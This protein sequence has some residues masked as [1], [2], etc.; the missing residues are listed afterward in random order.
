MRIC[1]VQPAMCSTIAENADAA[2]KWTRIAATHGAD[3]VAFPEMMLTGYDSH[4]HELF[5][6]PDWYDEVE[7]E[8]RG[9]SGVA[10]ETET[11]ILVGAPYRI[12]DHYLNAL[13]LLEGD[14]KPRLAGARGFIVE[15]WRKMWGF[16]EARDRAP[17]KI[18]GF[19]IGSIFC[20]E[21]S[22]LERVEDVG[23]EESEIILWPSGL[24]VKDGC[25]RRAKEIAGRFR[26][27]VI[28]STYALGAS[29]S[30]ND[31]ELCGGVV[32]NASG[33]ILIEASHGEETILS[34]DI[35]RRTDGIHV[36]AVSA[37]N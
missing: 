10:A 12:G 5:K 30:D 32:C 37:L 3:L 13:I 29:S 9:L 20:A 16:V 17:S 7:E 18:D 31:N 23:L 27:P 1:A 2:A 11:R 25:R 34:C 36:T 21:A 4:L 19:K 26:V 14:R 24:I 15:G 6:E 33:E 22:F 35:E 8:L 28:Q